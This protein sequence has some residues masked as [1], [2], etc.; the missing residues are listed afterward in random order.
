MKYLGY[1]FI[2]TFLCFTFYQQGYKARGME[3][4]DAFD[5]GYE[6]CQANFQEFIEESLP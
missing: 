4:L 6:A 1:L 2:L 5:K 3:V